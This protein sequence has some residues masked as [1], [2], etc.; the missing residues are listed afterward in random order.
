M[1]KTPDSRSD[2][3]RNGNGASGRRILPTPFLAGVLI[4]FVTCCMAGRWFSNRNCF[5]HLIRF[6]YAV[7]PQT[8]FYPTASQVRA[9]ARDQIDSEKIVVVVGGDSILYGFGQGENEVWTHSL[10]TVLGGQYQVI[11]LAVPG[12]H[13]SEFGAL[14]AEFLE[15][16]HPR[17]LF[18]TDCGTAM[19]D[20]SPD[21][22]IYRYFF[23]DAYY[24]GMVKPD[25]D[26]DQALARAEA[27]RGHDAGSTVDNQRLG[28]RLDASLRFQD[29]WTTVSYQYLSTVWTPMTS[30]TLHWPRKKYA[31]V[32]YPQRELDQRYPRSMDEDAMRIVRGMA[33]PSRLGLTQGGP[34]DCPL[35]RVVRDCFPA[36]CRNR[37]LMLVVRDSPYYVAK[38]DEQE[39]QEYAR[40]FP[41]FVR[42]L[43]GTGMAA[44]DVGGDYSEWDFYD[45]CHLSVQGGRRLAEDVAPKI[46]MM[47]DQLG[48]LKKGD[49]E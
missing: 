6:H 26:R 44:M 7:S 47:A 28:P 34:E 16:D 42:I 23:W 19:I 8:L 29:L 11:N 25:P 45:R 27:A 30:R 9:L 36:P 18:I 1:R 41:Q 21:G 33:G 38:L 12:A 24:K 49:H 4:A 35:A 31:D 43:E 46:R 3:Q 32:P 5:T 40:V 22:T 13:P 39:Q 14:T 20:E 17:L 37:T 10:Q 15:R 2:I 48:Y